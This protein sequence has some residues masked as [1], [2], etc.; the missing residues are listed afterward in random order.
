MKNILNNQTV[1]KFGFVLLLFV[2]LQIPLSMVSNLISERSSRLE[3][4]RN[5]IA[6]S[7]TG[8]QRIIGP[9]IMVKY[10]EMVNHEG[11]TYFTDY[12]KYLLPETFSLNAN[13]ESY[14]KHRGIYQARLYQADSNLTGTFDLK[15]LT[16]IAE[17]KIKSI[18][19]V[20]GVSDSRGLIKLRDMT[21]NGD[22]IEV[23]PGTGINQLV[24]GFHTNLAPSQL[25]ISSQ[26]T[27]DFNFI[28]QGMESIQVSPI[29]KVS[30]VEMTS[31]WPHPSF[32]GD[33]LP[34][35]S[36]VSDKG[37]SAH[38]TSNNFSSNIGQL[39]DLCMM[40]S[41]SCTELDRRQM[42]VDLI[43][44]VDH[45]LK[46]HRAVN[47]SL[48]VITLVFASFFLLEL[49]QARLMH[50]VQYGFV[51]LALAV[52]YLLLISLSEHLGFNLAYALSAVASTVLLSIYV[53]GILDN[54]KLGKLFGLCLIG[55]YGLLFGL[56]QAES[57]ALLMGSLLCFAILSLLMLITRHVDWYKK[58]EVTFSLNS[59]VNNQVTE[60]KNHIDNS[61][62]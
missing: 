60:P 17:E 26:M 22:N 40:N 10:T 2:L 36:K 13:L 9:F 37:F 43:E 44:P 24:Q 34:I 11:K 33:F 41:A 56:L 3:E 39:F 49:F 58:T 12:H 42:G 21:L 61:G 30:N 45:Y 14:A 48:L 4:V 28:L 62:A 53:S 5:E 59:V 27:F 6:R 51:G 52:F 20:V 15:P 7:S 1:T 54:A 57:Y 25:Q 23:K 29:G 38:W 55:L 46:S 8:E 35:S 31:P 16:E 47:Y 18:S 32:T 19:M 50:P